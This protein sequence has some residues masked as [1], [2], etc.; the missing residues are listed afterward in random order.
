MVLLALLFIAS[1]FEV[2][3]ILSNGVEIFS[4]S[5]RSIHISWSRNFRPYEFILRKCLPGKETPHLHRQFFFHLQWKECGGS[6]CT[7]RNQMPLDSWVSFPTQLSE[8]PWASNV[9]SLCL[10]FFIQITALQPKLWVAM[11]DELTN[12]HLEN[13]W[14][15][16][17]SLL[18]KQ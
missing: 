8:W 12:E 11:I 6:V 17:G 18:Y 10:S 13:A 14:H 4:E 9:T 7:L 2:E 1:G 5:H 16:A 3:R 15:V